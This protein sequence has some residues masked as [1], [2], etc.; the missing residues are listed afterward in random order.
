M[1]RPTDPMERSAIDVKIPASASALSRADGWCHANETSVAVLILIIGFLLRVKAVWGIFLNP[2]EALHFSFANQSS[3]VAAY[4]AS[5]NLAHP[6]LLVLLL[7][8][9][10]N[11]GT[12]DFMLRLPS[13]LAGIAFCWVLYL[14]LKEL[15]GST[16][17]LS[18]LAMTAWLAPLVALT[19]EVRQYSFSLLFITCSAFLLER[20]LAKQSA[21]TMT[22]SLVCLWLAMLSHYSALLFAAA[23]GIYSAIRLW[24][25]RPPARL[26]TAWIAG[27][28]GTA[29]LFAWLYR[30]HISQLKNSFLTEQAVSDWLQRSYFHPGK[31]VLAFIFGRTVAVF[32]FLFGQLAV[33]DVAALAFIAG[34]VV[35]FRPGRSLARAGPAAR[36]LAVFLLLPFAINCAVALAGK[37]P[38][39]GTRH[40]AFLALFAFAGI[41][42]FIAK[43]AR[44]STAIS[45]F[46][47]C[48]LIGTCYLFGFHHQPYMTRADQSRK[49]MDRA[50]E[51]IRTQVPAGDPLLVDYQTR[52]ML[53]HYLCGMQPASG[54]VSGFEEFQCAGHRIISAA[55]THWMFTEQTFPPYWDQ[56]LS[57]KNIPAGSFVWIVQ[58]GWGASIA[59][60]VARTRP[61]LKPSRS[62]NF[63]RNISAFQIRVPPQE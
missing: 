60:G 29:A 53:R 37:Y 41:A 48:V 62:V 50:V 36:G 58:A 1:P 28:F 18:G 11:I 4:H 59:P 44:G 45:L 40:S 23:L 52:I 16:A 22:C 19:S 15:I 20:A 14:W 49:Q 54:Y 25:I 56:F 33:G 7:Y 61:D 43:A 27:Q 42:S 24:H 9:W 51:F 5:L 21:W 10:R 2:D 46:V 3:F 34:V 35:L 55:P 17:A 47:I 31:N 6:P 57:E 39:G 13:I 38:Y 8:F 12:S 32:Q 30:V 63:G 26:L